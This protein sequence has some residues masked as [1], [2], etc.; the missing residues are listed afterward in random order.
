MKFPSTSNPIITKGDLER[1]SIIRYFV[2]HTSRQTVTEINSEQYNIFK[3]NPYYIVVKLPWIIVGP[4]SSDGSGK[5][6]VDEQ[7]LKIIN[8]YNKKM[9]GLNRKLRDTLEYYTGT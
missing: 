8:Y 9:H 5:L 1:G 3:N 7:N 6:S 4:L 2:K